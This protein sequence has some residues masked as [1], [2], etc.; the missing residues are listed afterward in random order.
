MERGLRRR[1][2]ARGQECRVAPSPPPGAAVAVV[3]VVRRREEEV[4]GG[5]QGADDRGP[6]RPRGDKRRLPPRAHQQRRPLGIPRQSDLAPAPAGSRCRRGERW[7][8]RRRCR[9]RRRRRRR[10][11][12]GGGGGGILLPQ[13]SGGGD[14]RL[15]RGRG[16]MEPAKLFRTGRSPRGWGG[17]HGRVGRVLPFLKYSFEGHFSQRAKSLCR[18]E[19]ERS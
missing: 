2:P 1:A 16:G 14:Y 7:I 17:G 10:I 5:R 19:R 4:A 3:S 12:G 13:R 15:L 18:E 9:R 11:A 6:P 8:L